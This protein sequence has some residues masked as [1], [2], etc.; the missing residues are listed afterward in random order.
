MC[1]QL[2]TFVIPVTLLTLTP[3]VDTLLVIRNSNRGG[4]RDGVTSSFGICSGLIVHALI[5]S[6][7]ISLIVLQSALA[8]SLL[9][10]AGAGYLL[11]LGGVS[12][13]SACSKVERLQLGGA[14]S[15][16]YQPRRS[17][18]E[19]LLSNVL[20]PKTIVFYMAFLPQ[21]IDPNGS[22]LQQSLLLA[23]IH[24]IIAMLY[25]TLLALLVERAAGWLDKPWVRRSLD[26]LAGVVMLLFGLKL[27]LER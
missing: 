12:L 16:D 27:A 13:R 18:M 21:F 24:F 11:W 22:V 26:G 6:L 14:R 1:E 20:N 17:F 2:L 10:I 8:F 15:R 19:G 5:S 7:G 9:K 25:Q 23:G 4:W 3:G